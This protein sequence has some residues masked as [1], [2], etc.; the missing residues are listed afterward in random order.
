MTEERLLA[1]HGAKLKDL[2]E[3]SP[4]IVPEGEAAKS[5]ATLQR[6]TEG[7]HALGLTR[8]QPVIALGGGA[9]GD[10]AGLAAALFM[11]GCPVV[12][13]PTTLLAQVDSAVGGKTAINACGRKNLVGA[14]HPPALVVCDP[15]L[16]ETLDQRQLRSG[17]AEV[18]KYGLVDDPTFFQWCEA[19]GRSLLEG[20]LPARRRAIEHCLKAK[21]RLIG[22]DL[23]DL[24]GRR[25]LL[26]LGHS[27]GHAIEA[28]T[29]CE[30]ILH[31]EA[32]AVGMMLAFSFSGEL[33]LCPQSEI[34]RVSAHLSACG[35][36]TSLAN[37][38]LAGRGSDLLPLLRQDKKAN[39]AG[40][41][42]IL[43]HGIGQAFVANEVPQDRIADFLERAD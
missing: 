1:L 21:A 37:L 39:S 27:F 36:P 42:L 17:Y 10:V 13:V 2:V 16:L 6:L 32:V 26:N 3:V 15:A 24:S 30:P 40:L 20:S 34:A 25:A 8:Q 41:V 12:H 14:F 28:Q 5:W 18:V 35:L 33:G 38:R 22:D 31:G 23:R 43:A 9:V 4:L 19:N 11:R 29:G 7:F